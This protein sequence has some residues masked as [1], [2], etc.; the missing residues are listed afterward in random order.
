MAAGAALLSLLSRVGVLGYVAPIALL[1]AGYALFQV[2]NNTML[3]KDLFPSD[4]GLSP[5][6]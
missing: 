4:V 3:M 6:W 2:A 5:V 1:T